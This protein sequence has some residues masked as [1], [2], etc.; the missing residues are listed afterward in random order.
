QGMVFQA[1]AGVSGSATFS[2][3]VSDGAGGSDSLAEQ[4]TLRVDNKA[5]ALEGANALPAV[6]EDAIDNPGMLVDALIAGHAADP[7]GRLG[8]A[9]VSA[10]SSA[11]QWQFSRDGGS[12]WAAF[13]GVSAA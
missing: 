12:H 7:G 13:D 4:L 9:V 6:D 1:A 2:F 11:G 5:P 8:V 10:A 3:T